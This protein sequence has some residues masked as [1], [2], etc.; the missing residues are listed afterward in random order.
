M[1]MLNY[2]KQVNRIIHIYAH[3]C[4]RIYEVVLKFLLVIIALVTFINFKW[5]IIVVQGRK[6]IAHLVG[7]V[8]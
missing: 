5:K 1:T 8:I 2:S 3:I 7:N 4:N 6:T